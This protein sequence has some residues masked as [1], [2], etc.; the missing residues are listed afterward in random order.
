MRNALDLVRYQAAL[1]QA[2][3]KFEP[4]LT[5]REVQ[6]VESRFNFVFPPDYR[7]FLMH[8]LPISEQFFNWRK[9]DEKWRDTETTHIQFWLAHP[10]EGIYFD[11]EYNEF[12]LPEWG[13]KPEELNDAL[14]IAKEAVAQAP[15]L[16]PIN[17]HRYIPASPEEEGNPIFS[18][19]QTDIIYYGRDLSEYLENEFRHVFGKE[20]FMLT[21]P[22]RPIPFWSRLVDLNT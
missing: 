11:I 13:P 22:I 18:V 3:V 9:P 17:G 15:V 1:E 2:G 14:A 19:M 20:H 16:I 6:Q 8:A 12:W 5:A 7:A 10:L 21:E 4:G